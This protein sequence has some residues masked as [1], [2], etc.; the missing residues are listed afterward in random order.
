MASAGQVR[1]LAVLQA[2]HVAAALEQHRRLPAVAEDDLAVVVLVEIDD[3]VSAAR[4]LVVGEFPGEMSLADDDALVAGCGCGSRD[5]RSCR[6]RPGRDR[7]R[8]RHGRGRQARQATSGSKA[9]GRKLSSLSFERMARH[10]SCGSGQ[11]ALRLLVG[12]INAFLSFVKSQR[13]NAGHAFGNMVNINSGRLRWR[14]LCR[15]DGQTQARSPDEALIR[16]ARPVDFATQHL[17]AHALQSIEARTA[18]L[19]DRNIATKY[20]RGNGFRTLT[21]CKKSFRET[22]AN[23]ANR[24]RRSSCRGTAFGA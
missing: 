4:L 24:A 3:V 2:V 9:S 17:R 18:V 1:Q 8:R 21:R 13:P 15:S 16:L 6:H 14:L 5:C 20:V 22:T 7:G 19:A 10:P 12:Q 23:V 11:I